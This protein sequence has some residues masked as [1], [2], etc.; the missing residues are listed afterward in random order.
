MG[1]YQCRLTSAA[2]CA[3]K[4]RSQE[5]DCAAAVKKLEKDLQNGPFHCF[6]QHS[7]CSP[8]F[9]RIA[10]EKANQDGNGK[11]AGNQ[12]NDDARES[13]I[14]DQCGDNSHGSDDNN[15]QNSENC[16]GSE[17]NGGIDILQG[18]IPAIINL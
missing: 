4:M 9:C 6:G 1:D 10:R 17:S 16:P 8:D 11:D 5:A 13:D 2:R 7:K 14:D 15:V 12:G 3:I 18:R